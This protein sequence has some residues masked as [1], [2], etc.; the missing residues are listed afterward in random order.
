LQKIRNGFHCG[1]S[2]PSFAT[3][4]N[5]AFTEVGTGIIDYKEIFKHKDEAGMKYFFVEQDVVKIPVYESI[6][7]SFDYIKKNKLG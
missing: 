2:D 7:K 3:D 6:A 1:I 4:G 5:Q